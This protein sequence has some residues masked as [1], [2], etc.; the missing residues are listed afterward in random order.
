[1]KYETRNSVRELLESGASIEKIIVQ[2]SAEMRDIVEMANKK[3]I[4]IQFAE[5]SE[6][7]TLSTTKKH[8]GVIAFGADFKYSSVEEILD[9]AKSKQEDVFIL[10]LDGLEDPHNLGSVLRVAECAGVHGVIIPKNRA[11]AVTET[12]VRVSAGATQY[13]KVARV[14]NINRTIEELKKQGVFVFAADMK[15]QSIYDT[16]LTGN[17]AI[18]IGSEGAGVSV[19]TKKLSDG[20]IS[21]PMHGKINS[22]NAS[23]S[24]GIVVYEA[25]RQ[26]HK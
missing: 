6:L 9:L 7:D 13:T 3:N 12:V 11:V 23:V 10:I 25:L 15:G 14:T 19:L 1:M 21:I 18:V 20:I 2:K 5:K 22:L 17:I 4:K 24:T 26:R 16:N 8:Q